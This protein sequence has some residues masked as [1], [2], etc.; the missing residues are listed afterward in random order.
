MREQGR[1]RCQ[2]RQFGEESSRGYGKLE[3][4]G[5]GLER[6]LLRRGDY[7]RGMRWIKGRD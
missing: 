6:T 3:E 7:G 2:E 1:G 5:G 4:I